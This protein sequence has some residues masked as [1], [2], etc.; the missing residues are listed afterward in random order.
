MFGAIQ[1]I[2]SQLPDIHALRHVNIL[3]TFW[4]LQP[5]YYVNSISLCFTTQNNTDLFLSI[6]H[7]G[8]ADLFLALLVNHLTGVLAL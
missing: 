2:L 4:T 3:V 5:T 7:T 1:L 8:V 6:W